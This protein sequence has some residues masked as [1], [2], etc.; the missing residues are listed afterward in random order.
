MASIVM[1]IICLLLGIVTLAGNDRHSTRDGAIGSTFVAAPEPG[2]APQIR[3]RF[4]RQTDPS[5]ARSGNQSPEH[6]R[7]EA[8][9]RQP[10]SQLHRAR[11]PRSIDPSELRV[12]LNSRSAKGRAGVHIA[13]L[14]VIENVVNFPTKLQ[15][16]GFAMQMKVLENGHVPVVRAGKPDHIFRRV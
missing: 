9:K 15:I 12:G 6:F 4:E 1:L 8:L 2:K 10:Q 16:T 5:G 13:E 11:I 14:S 3:S 7:P